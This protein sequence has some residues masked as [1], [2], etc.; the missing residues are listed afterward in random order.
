M[1][2]KFI[3]ESYSDKYPHFTAL[4]YEIWDGDVDPQRL[5]DKN[6][7]TIDQAESAAASLAAKGIDYLP[8]PDEVEYAVIVITPGG[9]ELLT[10][11][12]QEDQIEDGNYIH[13]LKLA[14]KYTGKEQEAE[15]KKE[16]A[17]KEYHDEYVKWIDIRNGDNI[18]SGIQDFVVVSKSEQEEL[19]V[20]DEGGWSYVL[21]LPSVLQDMHTGRLKIINK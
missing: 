11:L 5:I 16:K 17:K 13:N 1:K 15:R 3:N 9:R 7:D 21:S 4:V 19:N 6:P 10:I 8:F 2:A 18:K 14:K 12:G 20:E